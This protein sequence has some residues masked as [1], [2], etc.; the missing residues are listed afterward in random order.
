MGHQGEPVAAHLEG[1]GAGLER[2]DL[3]SL[4]RRLETHVPQ[5]ADDDVAR[6]RFAVGA[7]QAFEVERVEQGG[8][9]GRFHQ[10]PCP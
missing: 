4:D 3:E 10:A 6:T 2:P 7:G 5:L 9:V 8:G 1:R